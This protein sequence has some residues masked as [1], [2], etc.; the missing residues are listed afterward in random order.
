MNRGMSGPRGEPVTDSALRSLFVRR[1]DASVLVRRLLSEQAL[2]HWRLY[3]ISFALMAVA[4]AC[5]A[6]SAYLLGNVINEAYVD[7]NFPGIVALA[8]TIVALFAIKGVAS[9][10]QAVMLSRIGARIIA[11]NQRAMFDKLLNE[12]LGYF[13]T[14]HST[15]FLAR[16]AA[17]ANSASFVINLLITAVGRDLLSVIGLGVV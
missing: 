5:T 14:R 3:T 1:D 4:A 7:R 8:V 12:G 9:Y 17:G 2:V 11:R 16:L 10:G 13:T 6:A 15:D